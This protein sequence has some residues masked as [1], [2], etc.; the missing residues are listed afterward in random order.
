LF[1]KPERL[2][3]ICIEF[4]DSHTARGHLVGSVILPRSMSTLT[5]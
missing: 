5:V 4:G 2:C 1:A 3:T